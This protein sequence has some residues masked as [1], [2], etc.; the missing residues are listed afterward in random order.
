MRLFWQLP[1]GR[2]GLL[3]LTGMW[4]DGCF[5]LVMQK[6]NKQRFKKKGDIKKRVTFYSG[7][8]CYDGTGG[9]EADTWRSARVRGSAGQLSRKRY[10]FN[11]ADA[12]SPSRSVRSCDPATSY[13]KPPFVFV[14]LPLMNVETLH[15]D[16]KTSPGPLNTQSCPGMF[17]VLYLGIGRA[18]P[19]FLPVSPTGRSFP[20]IPVNADYL[21]RDSS[22]L[23]AL[24]QPLPAQSY[25]NIFTLVYCKDH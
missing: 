21:E 13:F 5:S 15:V 7:A 14:F 23:L 16:W 11:F 4:K 17:A 18:D 10:C 8:S 25:F 3:C 1:G 20:H 9:I 12:A 22:S 2:V 19:R 6:R 24:F